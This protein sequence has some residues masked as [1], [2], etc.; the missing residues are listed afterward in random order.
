MAVCDMKYFHLQQARNFLVLLSGWNSA[1]KEFLVL[2][3]YCNWHNLQKVGQSR[4]R[5]Y[6]TTIGRSNCNINA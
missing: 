2:H 6:H 5:I 1:P 4:F 3:F